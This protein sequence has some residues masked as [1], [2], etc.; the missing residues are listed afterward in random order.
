MRKNWSRFIMTIAT[1]TAIG[2]SCVVNGHAAEISV[3][4]LD[5]AEDTSEYDELNEYLIQHARE[6]LGDSRTR[7]SVR[8]TGINRLVQTDSRWKNV[9][10]NGDNE[11]GLTIGQA[12]CCLTSFT[13]VRNL[14]SGTSDTPADVN[15]A[16]GNG[17]IPFNWET[18][19]STYDYTI[20]TKRRDDS[21]ISKESIYLNVVGA[22]D[23]YSRP[24][25]IGFKLTS[26]PSKTH[27][28]VGHGYTTEG[29]I[30]ICDPASRNYTAISQYYDAGYYVYEFY[31][32]SKRE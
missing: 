20:L 5:V 13:M 30:I 22:I 1:I 19:K 4:P 29:E 6:I 31:V 3:G 21:G 12:G 7:T 9:V 8:L 27:F 15:T 28:V 16:L 24:V 25:I 32:Y 2:F 11:R 17:A 26:D 14:L 10:L 18:A 23:E